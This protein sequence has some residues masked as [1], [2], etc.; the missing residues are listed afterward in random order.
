MAEG[1][2]TDGREKGGKETFPGTIERVLFNA[3]I[4]LG[5]LSKDP[6]PRLE[7]NGERGYPG[8][9]GREGKTKITHPSRREEPSSRTSTITDPTK[10]HG[11]AHQTKKVGSTRFRGYI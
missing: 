5:V 7:Q 3:I 2:P 8:N 11:I 4:A 9:Q 1:T 10:G 6:N